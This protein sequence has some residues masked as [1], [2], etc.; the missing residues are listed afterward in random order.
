MTTMF[1]INNPYA[2]QSTAPADAIENAR[3]ESC[4]TSPV[5]CMCNACGSIAKVEQH[6]ATY[7]K[8][9]TAT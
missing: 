6:A 8:I 1:P 2:S 4:S 3:N 9:S 5:R 7:P